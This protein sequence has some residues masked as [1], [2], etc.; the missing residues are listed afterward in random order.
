AG[1]VVARAPSAFAVRHD[2]AR[3][4]Y[5]LEA[6]PEKGL[7]WE[8][9][10]FAFRGATLE[11]EN[12]SM[13]T[14]RDVTGPPASWAHASF[15]GALLGTAAV[16]IARVA[17]RRAE[18]RASEGIAATHEGDGWIVT[19]SPAA[20]LQVTAVA[21]LPEGP[22]V[23]EGSWKGA[24]AGYREAGQPEVLVRRAHAG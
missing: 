10:D 5:V 12:L 1:S 23:L 6:Q 2:R 13:K 4:L 22:V 15:L 9:D 20:R 11:P 24:G 8:F 7:R 17:E 19:T 21:K 3:D 14:T 18:R 16:L